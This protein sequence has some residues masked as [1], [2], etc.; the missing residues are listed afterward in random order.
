MADQGSEG[1]LSPFLRER[2]FAA[3]RPF[4][5][6][7]VLDVGC[8]TGRLTKYSTPGNYF[9][10]E[11]D[12]E[13]LREARASNPGYTFY[14]Q[15]PP[16]SEKFD[17]IVALAVIEHTPSPELFLQGLACRLASKSA[18]RIVISTPHPTMDFIHTLGSKLGIFSAHASEEHETLL[19]KRALK[20]CGF[21]ANLSLGVY[22]RFL[23]GANQ[24]CV[25]FPLKGD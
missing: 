13:S 8:G 17:T 9:G 25:Y 23:L 21:Q 4:I 6:G 22:R 14:D 12:A 20:R 1:L 15:L 18:S 10:V 2:R 5:S 11:Q 19:D 16:A 7:R 24:L 3:A